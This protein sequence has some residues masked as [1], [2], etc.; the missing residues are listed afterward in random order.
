[1]CKKHKLTDLQEEDAKI[2]KKLF[3]IG[4]LS[5]IEI[6]YSAISPGK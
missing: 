2:K 6:K 5:H 3:N 1:M 4:H